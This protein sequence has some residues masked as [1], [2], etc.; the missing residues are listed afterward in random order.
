MKVFSFSTDLVII[1]LLLCSRLSIYVAANHHHRGAH[2]HEAIISTHFGVKSPDNYT[3]GLDRLV[4]IS[5]SQRHYVLD[6]FKVPFSWVNPSITLHDDNK[7][8]IMIWRLPDK[9]NR[10]RIGFMHMDR[11]T[12]TVT[13]PP[14]YVELIVENKT[15]RL[16]LFGE[17]ARIFRSNGRLFLVYNTH[18]TNYEK[19][20]FYFTPMQYEYITSKEM[21][22]NNELTLYV[23]ETPIAVN[24]EHEMGNMHQKN[25]APFDYI[26]MSINASTST[27]AGAQSSKMPSDSDLT[28][29]LDPSIKARLPSFPPK[30]S[31]SG[32]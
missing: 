26:P 11:H 12:W 24:C 32:Q 16:I 5:I 25:W 4:N 10:D 20:H 6:T 13:K 15:K 21:G 18:F 30:L 3:D 29:M 23:N 8:V 2:H 27:S 31:S 19:R 17:D 28:S 14:D 9:R 22:L 7:T 1:L